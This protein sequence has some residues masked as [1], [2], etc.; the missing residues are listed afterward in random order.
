[1]HIVASG[2]SALHL[3]HGSRESLAGRFERVT[4]THWTAS[5]LADQFKLSALEAVD[6]LVALG[7]YPGAVPYRADRARWSAYVRDAIV[8]PAIGRDILALAPVR[9]PGLLRQVFGVCAVSPAQI[10]SLQKIQGQ[11]QD[12]G[13]LETI[14]YYLTLL[15]D[16]FLVAP[17]T[18]YAVRPA[19][20]R[21]APPKLVTLSNALL[22]ASDPRGIPDRVIDP[23]RYGAWVENACLAHAWS[24]GQQV[25]YWREQPFEV[26]GVIDGTWGSWAIEV[27]TGA[28]APADVRGL[29]EFTRRHPK[30]RPVVLCDDEARVAVERAGFTV[31]SW[32]SFLMQG[33]GPGT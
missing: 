31:M 9:K 4:L 16:A 21:A 33:L 28:I 8:E 26:D 15:E 24:Q 25:R 6:T 13:A 3:A 10:V 2:S 17:L 11:L 27:K 19:R 5:A 18:K 23:T 22:A 32:R 14:A 20:Q 12:A 29:G 7:A 1:V 30:Y